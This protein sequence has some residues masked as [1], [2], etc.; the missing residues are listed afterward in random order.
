MSN[1]NTTLSINSIADFQTKVNSIDEEMLN[2]FAENILECYEEQETHQDFIQMI[3]DDKQP[4]SKKVV[5]KFKNKLLNTLIPNIHKNYLRYIIKNQFRGDEEAYIK[6]V[7]LFFSMFSNKDK[8]ICD[9][10]ITS[11]CKKERRKLKKQ[12]KQLIL[13]SAQLLKLMGLKRSAIITNDCVNYYKQEMQKTDDFLAQYR[14]V[15]ADG[16]ISK[17]VSNEAKQKQKVA[18]ILKISECMALMAK[19]KGFSFMLVTL[20]LPPAFHCNAYSGKDSFAGYTPAE[21]LAAINRYWK[22]IR[23]KLHNE[24]YKVGEDFFGIQVLELQGGSTL[25]LHC[26]LY[27]SEEDQDGIQEAI[28]RV[29]V[30]EN[31]KY[32]DKET[33]SIEQRKFNLA[34][35]VE[36]WDVSIKD[37]TKV[38]DSTNAGARYV[39]KY[40]MKTHTNYKDER[41]DDSALKNIAARFF[42]N[43]RGFNF[44]G[45]KGSITKFN[46]LQKNFTKYTDV[47]DR[48][49][50]R[51]LGC[52]DYYDFL[53]NYEKYFSNAYTAE[54]RFIGVAFDKSRY[55]EE[56]NIVA[57]SILNNE[58]VLISKKQYCV[59]ERMYEQ[60]LTNVK[61]ADFTKLE[62]ANLKHAYDAVQLK[63]AAHEQD[64]KKYIEESGVVLA[65]AEK[66][67]RAEAMKLYKFASTDFIHD[68]EYLDLDFDFDLNFA[69]HVEVVQLLY[70]IQEKRSSTNNLASQIEQHDYC[71]S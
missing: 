58:T 26:L 41:E 61:Q 17:L 11:Q 44:F 14:L 18:Q 59:F 25:H 56:N 23:A 33:H 71:D 51:V 16:A 40:I 5:L 70:N 49:L 7:P 67:S 27:S 13:Y 12:Q 47:L 32:Q 39:F 22:G 30:L 29:R 54:K 64:F 69:S 34:H 46:F 50:C 3:R 24:G 2:Y 37:D 55:E 31:S 21:A 68:Y 53:H 35:R 20:T 10:A 38:T 66:L 45:M 4:V 62:Y 15:S 6:T 19:D 63:Q 65:T 1:K 52:G 48:D 28:E 42:Y 60:E 8:L 43:C 9:D 36:M 57:K